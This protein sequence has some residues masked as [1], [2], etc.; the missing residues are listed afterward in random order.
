MSPQRQK[1]NLMVQCVVCKR[2][3]RLGQKAPAGSEKA[4]WGPGE[5]GSYCCDT[6]RSAWNKA[7][8]AE[9]EIIQNEVKSILQD[10]KKLTTT[11]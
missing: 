9:L 3:G 7:A 8:Q 5:D 4:W 1:S 11:D 10:L 2:R 6:C